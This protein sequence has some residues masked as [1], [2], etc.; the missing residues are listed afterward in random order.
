MID[1][2]LIA[3]DSRPASLPPSGPNHYFFLHN[4]TEPTMRRFILLAAAVNVFGAACS[5][6]TG[7]ADLSG[8]WAGTAAP[9]GCADGVTEHLE[10]AQHGQSLTGTYS[11][12]DCFGGTDPG[13]ISFG[14][15]RGDTV[16]FNSGWGSFVGM[17]SGWKIVGHLGGWGSAPSAVLTRTN[18]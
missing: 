5:N 17:V 18:D 7:P 6:S 15:V 8:S 9:T 14:Y 4:Q 1:P 11:L 3:G 16:V 12:R 10:L 13:S 2:T